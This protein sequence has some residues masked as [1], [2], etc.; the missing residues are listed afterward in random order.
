MKLEDI[1]LK[2]LEDALT[3]CFGGFKDDGEY[4]TVECCGEINYGSGIMGTDIVT[5]KGC[6]KEIRNVLS[7]HVSPLLINPT[8]H[9]T[10]IPT[11]EFFNEVG[12]KCW[13]VM[14]E[15]AALVEQNN[16]DFQEDHEEHLRQRFGR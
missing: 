14:S 5:C 3:T 6:G 10:A 15:L 12:D 11:V 13:I 4:I 9:T 2:T 16:K 1:P 8:M 7:P